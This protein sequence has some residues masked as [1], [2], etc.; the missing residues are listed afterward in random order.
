MP[1]TATRPAPAV[2]DLAHVQVEAASPRFIPPDRTLL[3][4][5]LHDAGDAVTVCRDAWLRARNHRREAD[6]IQRDAKAVHKAAQNRAAL[7]GLDVT[8]VP[9]QRPAKAAAQA[10]AVEAE[11][12][13]LA[14]VEQRW[15]ELIDGIAT[16]RARIINDITPTLT[17]AEQ[18]LAVVEKAA[19]D[20]RAI[21]ERLRSQR[22]W[23]AA[24]GRGSTGR[25]T[26]ENGSP[27]QP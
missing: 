2:T 25:A 14:A 17:D 24:I 13:A 18:Q 27:F 26:T 22:D 12:A 23:L 9:D 21:T 19:A 20:Q 8:A 11:A 15:R 10:A 4:P 6:R 1:K 5:E 7:D 3:P 16:H